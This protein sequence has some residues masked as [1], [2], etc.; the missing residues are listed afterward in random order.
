MS[1]LSS[2]LRR[3]VAAA[4]GALIAAGG[5]AG[6]AAAARP[7]VDTVAE[8]YDVTAAAVAA[9][10]EPQVTDSRT[11]AI[12]WLA[13]ARALRR[14]PTFTEPGP[15]RQYR[16]AALATAVHHALRALVP[17]RAA[18]LDAALATTLGR[19]PAGAP[20]ERGV[21][22]G[23]TEAAELLGARTGDGL[24]PAGVNA[25]FPTP[26]PAPGVWQP[27]PPTFDPA[28]QAGNRVAKPFVLP[29]ADRF[30]PATPPAVGSAPYHRDLA[31]V[32]A[33]GSAAST[34]RTAA[35]TDTATFWLGS[36]LTLYTGVLRAAVV[37]SAAPT[38]DRA[39]LV[40]VFHAALVDTQIATSD[41][42]YAYL[43]WRPVT[44]IRAGGEAAWTPLHRTPAHPDYPSGHNTYSGAAEAVLTALVGEHARAP[45]SIGSPTQPGAVRTYRAWRTL[46]DENVDARVFS[47]IHTRTAD[48]V[49][50][51][52]GRRVGAYAVRNAGAL[53]D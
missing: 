27:T 40:A 46:T 15:A 18:P 11:W 45:F 41:A 29:A 30:R 43:T 13:A 50:A 48:I 36:S 53:L 37:Q 23:R 16:D 2:P 47:G 10:T 44:A 39:A 25:P 4:T 33:Y 19:I 3:A 35:Q 5:L 14:T 22:A 24:D 1:V 49:G 8:W 38:A 26:Q 34:A 21:A 7:E 42:K 52:L 32:R 6:P 12:G 31:E 20:R 51:E 9:G 17:D 28:Q